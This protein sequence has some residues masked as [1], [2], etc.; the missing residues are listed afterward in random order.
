MYLFIGQDSLHHHCFYAINIPTKG[1]VPSTVI[2]AA[3]VASTVSYIA[4]LFDTPYDPVR[5]DMPMDPV[6]PCYSLSFSKDQVEEYK[7]VS[8]LLK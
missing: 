2:M 7:E 5:V 8:P 4:H 1:G 6:E 3:L